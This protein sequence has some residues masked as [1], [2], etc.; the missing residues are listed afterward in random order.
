MAKNK[1]LKD[2]ALTDAVAKQPWDASIRMAAF[3][4][5][6][7]RL[8]GNVQWTSDPNEQQ[9]RR[10]EIHTSAAAVEQPAVAS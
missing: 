7:E 6:V 4:D 2:Q 1:G 9:T 8:A 3:P 5:V 10:P